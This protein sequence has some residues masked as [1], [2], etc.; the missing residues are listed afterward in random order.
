MYP[1]LNKPLPPIQGYLTSAQN[2]GMTLEAMAAIAAAISFGVNLAVLAYGLAAFQSH[3]DQKLQDVDNH[4]GVVETR[5]HEDMDVNVINLKIH[6]LKRDVDPA[7]AV[8]IA[9]LVSKY[10][11][12]YQRDPDLIL[13][14]IKVESGFNP[15]AVS[16]VGATGL[17]QLMP[18]WIKIFGLT[19]DLTDP[20]V[21]IRYGM[22]VLNFY[23][24]MYSGNVKLGLIAYNAGPGYVNSTEKPNPEYANKVISVYNQLKELNIGSSSNN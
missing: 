4:L 10:A 6:V 14:V 22:Q 18:H 15:N 19:G 21:S 5:L 13:A 1:S 7:F 2:T 16:E 11:K 12:I 24:G 8:Q 23:S 3:I 20:E 17:M 9:K